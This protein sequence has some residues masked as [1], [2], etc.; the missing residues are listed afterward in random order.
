[1]DY[2][3]IY[4]II[5]LVVIF[6]LFL[7]FLF[8]SIKEKRVSVVLSMVLL[9]IFVMSSVSILAMLII[10]EYTK[11]AKIIQLD[12][13]RV[14]INESIVFTGAI[15]NTGSHTITSCKFNIK[16]VNSPVEKGKLD[17]TIFQ[18]RGFFEIFKRND[19][20]LST[21]SASFTIGHS[22]KAGETRS[23]SVSMDYPAHFRS[24]SVYHTLSCH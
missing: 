3:T 2:F 13:N 7:V 22:L 4:H 16:L 21:Q 10:D 9:N 6:I 24:P 5:A 23:F 17:P 11:I 12:Q 19:T 1:M 20:Q 18:T 15:K 8:L 14:L